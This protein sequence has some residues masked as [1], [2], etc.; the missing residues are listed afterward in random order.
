MEEGY[1]GGKLLAHF[2][3]TRKQK[4]RVRKGQR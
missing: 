2:L 3:A 1:G 4:S